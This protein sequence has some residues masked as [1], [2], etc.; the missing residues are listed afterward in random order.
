MNVRENLLVLLEFLDEMEADVAG[1]KE[2]GSVQES[3]ER[4]RAF[5]EKLSL[6]QGVL[7]LTLKKLNDA[8]ARTSKQIGLLSSWQ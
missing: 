5:L 6:F 4:R 7:L 8:E 2:V 3:I 1:M